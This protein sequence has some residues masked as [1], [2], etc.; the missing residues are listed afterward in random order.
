[1][2][3]VGPMSKKTWFARRPRVAYC[4]FGDLFDLK[5]P[6]VL[7]AVEPEGVGRDDVRRR[8]GAVDTTDGLP[9]CEVEIFGNS[10]KHAAAFE[11]AAESPVDDHY[12]A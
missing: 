10:G 3:P 4:R 11:F 1:M 12:F 5:L 6:A 2:P 9:V 7:D 8:I